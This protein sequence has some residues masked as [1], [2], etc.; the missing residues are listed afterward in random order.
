MFLQ[1][2]PLH[3]APVRTSKACCLFDHLVVHCTIVRRAVV[4]KGR[5]R[6]KS[7]S[8]FRHIVGRTAKLA[9]HDDVTKERRGERNALTTQAGSAVARS[10]RKAARASSRPPNRPAKIRK[11]QTSP[12]GTVIVVKL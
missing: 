5:V 4:R 6:G 9:G 8:V 1:G 3:F 7:C 10:S 11:Q 2:G 12:N